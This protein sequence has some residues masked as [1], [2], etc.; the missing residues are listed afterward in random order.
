MVRAN[1][2]GLVVVDGSWAMEGDGPTM[3]TPV[4]MGLIIAGTNPLATDMLTANIMG[5]E[6]H[7]VPTFTWANRVGMSPTSISEIEVR[8]ETLESV[9]RPF[10]KPNV[11]PWTSISEWFAKEELL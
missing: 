7:E 8:G 4:Q 5:F 6:P 11:V 10:V 9:R 2:L 1:K 3:G